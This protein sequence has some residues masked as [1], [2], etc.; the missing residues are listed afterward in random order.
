MQKSVER[1]AKKENNTVLPKPKDKLTK[2]QSEM[3]FREPLKDEVTL[4]IDF[5]EI[6][7]GRKSLIDPE[8]TTL[9]N[10]SKVVLPVPF[11]SPLKY[12]FAK[13]EDEMVFKFAVTTAGDLVGFVYLEIPHKF[14][15]I[16]KFKLDDW[17]PVKLVQTA[18]QEKL[19]IENFMKVKLHPVIG[20]QNFR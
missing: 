7:Y 15:S 14:K 11:D 13:A 8:I 4:T 10:N 6:R 18:D 9:V 1:K 3:V 16:N 5:K 17:F 2:T 20:V 12:G 19:K